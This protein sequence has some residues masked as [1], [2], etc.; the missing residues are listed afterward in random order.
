M[1]G[2]TVRRRARS[3]R[4]VANLG[5]RYARIRS[6]IQRLQSFGRA[7]EEA[8][9]GQISL[10]DPDARAMATS[11]RHSGLVGYN[12]QAAVETETPSHVTHEVTNLAHDRDQLA[13]I[14]T[15]AKEVL[16]REEMSARS[17][18]RGTS[19]D[20]DTRLPRGRIYPPFPAR[21]HPATV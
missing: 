6:E 12:A 4:E 19:A 2:S 17:P 13:A 20:A 14:A 21:R 11:A 1:S 9:D 3:G 15:G 10:T 16:E 7:L 5:R 8:P 18:T